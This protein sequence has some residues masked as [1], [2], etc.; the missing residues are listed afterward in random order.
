MFN[1]LILT[2]EEEGDFDLVRVL[3][4]GEHGGPLE[5]ALFCARYRRTTT[6]RVRAG[7]LK[8][9]EFYEVSG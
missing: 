6:E 4:V 7:E 8:E 9:A 5:K 1:S 2:R 3:D